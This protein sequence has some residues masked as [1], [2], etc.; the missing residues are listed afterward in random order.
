MGIQANLIQLLDNSGRRR[1]VSIL[2]PTARLKFLIVGVLLSRIASQVLS[3]FPSSLRIEPL[4]LRACSRRLTPQL[5]STWLIVA[6]QCCR[7][8]V[9]WRNTRTNRGSHGPST[10][11]GVDCSYDFLI[12][13]KCRLSFY[14]TWYLLPIERSQMCHFPSVGIAHLDL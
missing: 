5:T 14:R 3:N 10:T 8:R 4:W 6:I 11:Q 12:A 7:L 2:Q 13:Q 9:A 1:S